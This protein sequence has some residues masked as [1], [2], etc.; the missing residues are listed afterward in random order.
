MTRREAGQT[1]SGPAAFV[2]RDGL[3]AAFKPGK[4]ALGHHWVLFEGQQEIGRTRLAYES[5]AAKTLGRL[6]RATG[7]VTKGVTHATITDASGTEL[8]RVH[9]YPKDKRVELTGTD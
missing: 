4:S 7:M 3:S 5:G 8:F 1:D 2:A 9:S 6:G